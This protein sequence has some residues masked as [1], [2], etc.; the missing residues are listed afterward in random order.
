MNIRRQHQ[1]AFLRPFPNTGIMKHTTRTPTAALRYAFAALVTLFVMKVQAQTYYY[2]DQIVV[3]PSSP[4]TADDI[5]ITVNGSLS[6]TT[7]FITN[8]SW[9]A[10]GSVVQLT[11]NAGEQGLGLDVLVP[12]SES[13]S[14]GTLAA[15]DYSIAIGG[16]SMLDLATVPEHHFTVTGGGPTDCDSL[17]IMSIHWG[18]FSTGQLVVTAA[19]AS[20]DLFDYPGFVMLDPGGDTIAKE[21]V[22]Y[23]GI[24]VGPQEHILDVVDGTLI[25]GNALQGQLHLWSNF[26]TEAEC[27]FEGT[28]D[29]C[30]STECTMVAPYL[31]NMGNA[32]VEANIPY[33]VV[34]GDGL[35]MVSGVFEL[36]GNAQ[37]DYESGVCLAR[38]VYTLQLDQI[39]PVGGQLFY[40]VAA[41]MMNF[42]RVQTSYEQGTA[43]TMPFAVYETCT[44]GTNGVEAISNNATI[45]LRQDG[46]RLIVVERNG[47]RIGTYRL[48]DTNGRIVGTGSLNTDRGDIQL[49]S[50]APGTY[51]LLSEGSGSARFIR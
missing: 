10:A 29:L 32:L 41:D 21:T 3:T 51:V 43:N 17:D 34:N 45:G 28:W 39:S 47:S 7:S 18:V 15:G 2:I 8:T 12:H 40:G 13:F 30:P 23:F 11:V 14:I 9:N 42:E 49:T 44:D 46:D 1:R 35:T 4:T 33:A 22:N 19:N 20:S 37:S 16:T 36:S 25:D 27:Q 48:L 6:T 38:D 24:G 31:V 26:Y 5:T 50:L